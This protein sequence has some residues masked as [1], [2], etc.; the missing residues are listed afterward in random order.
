MYSYIRCSLKIV[1]LCKLSS[2]RAINYRTRDW[3]GYYHSSKNNI[4]LARHYHDL[5]LTAVV[6]CIKSQNLQ[7]HPNNV[8]GKLHD[9]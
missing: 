2:C 3:H 9:G 7:M 6:E 4:V 1:Y 8:W 5:C